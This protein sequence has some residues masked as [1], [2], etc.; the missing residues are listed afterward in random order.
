MLIAPPLR[1]SFLNMPN[2]DL[3]REVLDDLIE[4]LPVGYTLERI[5]VDSS[6]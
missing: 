4:Q 5:E 1:R 3:V 2:K 6:E